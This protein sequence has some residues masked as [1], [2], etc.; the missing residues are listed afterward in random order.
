MATLPPETI[1]LPDDSL[2]G[3]VAGSVAADAGVAGGLEHAWLALHWQANEVAHLAQI[4][5]EPAAAPI[6]NLIANAQPWRRNLAA[7][8]VDDVTAMLGS[9]LAALATLSG[10]G[11]DTAAPA[12][13]LW[14]EFHAARGALVALLQPDDSN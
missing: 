4:A 6:A 8:G 3:P 7:Q 2:A 9:G 13:A 14:R 5:A 1:L 11:Q 10:R 12:L